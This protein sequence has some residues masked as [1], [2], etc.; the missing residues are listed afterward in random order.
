M[1]KIVRERLNEIKRAGEE[2]HL[3]MLG[4]GKT[5][6]VQDWIDQQGVDIDPNAIINRDGTI[7]AYYVI[8]R[9]PLPPYVR[10]NK[11]SRFMVSGEELTRDQIKEALPREIVSELNI[12]LA[13]D[14]NKKFD[15][16]FAKE[17][18]SLC[19]HYDDLD[20]ELHYEFD[21]NIPYR[22]RKDITRQHR[23]AAAGNKISDRTNFLEKIY[24]GDDGEPLSY[25][26]SKGYILYWQLKYVDSKGK[27]GAYYMN[28]YE[29]SQLIKYPDRKID[30]KY[31]GNY[32]ESWKEFVTQ[33]KDGWWAITD[34]GKRYLEEHRY[35]EAQQ[36]D[37]S[38]FVEFKQRNR[39]NPYRDSAG[40]GGF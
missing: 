39:P 27:E 16:A 12:I 34:K 17:L 36:P 29:I 22:G 3:S 5:K 1:K 33:V 24:R 26:W 7:N 30:R 4:V 13:A 6:A 11:V 35:F 31:L 18:L 2:S 37:L 10:F 9:V 38:K 23:L 20:V 19:K 14:S 8:V 15:N 21:S 32:R 40:R 25:Q 28:V